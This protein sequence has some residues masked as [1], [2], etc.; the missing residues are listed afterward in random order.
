MI[1]ES[2]T[3]LF[4]ADQA[5]STEFYQEILGISSGDDPV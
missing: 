5:K 4:V 3:I 2:H 1:K